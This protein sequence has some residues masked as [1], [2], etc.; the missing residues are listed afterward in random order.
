MNPQ[1]L[2][3]VLRS[4]EQAVLAGRLRPIYGL[5]TGVGAN[6]SIDVEPDTAGAQGLLRSHATAAGAPRSADRVRAMLLIRLNQLCA[7]GAGPA[8]GRGRAPWP[9]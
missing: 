9:T 3:R 6:R 8:A 4:H 1:A 2:D 7:G 5:T